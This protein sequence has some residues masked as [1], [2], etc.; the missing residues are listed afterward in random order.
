MSSTWVSGHKSFLR[1]EISSQPVLSLCVFISLSLSTCLSVC[2][3]LFAS[4]GLCQCLSLS[5]SVSVCLSV[6]HS[7]SEFLSGD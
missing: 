2:R 1:C 6:C 5:A 4:V 7:A 3:F